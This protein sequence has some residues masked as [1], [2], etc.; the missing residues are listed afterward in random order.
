MKFR[1]KKLKI[2]F[3]LGVNLVLQSANKLN[4]KGGSGII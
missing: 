3:I 1:A 4:I 2:A